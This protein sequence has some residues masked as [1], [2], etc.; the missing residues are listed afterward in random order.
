MWKLRD[1][2]SLIAYLLVHIQRG[3]VILPSPEFG[4][5]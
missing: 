1:H 4:S 2:L 3:F 5:E